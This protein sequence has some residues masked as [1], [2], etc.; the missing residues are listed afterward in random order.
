MGAPDLSSQGP[1][2]YLSEWADGQQTIRASSLTG[3]TSRGA[4]DAQGCVSLLQ[5][6][7]NIARED[8]L[9]A[10]GLSARP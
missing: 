2:I 9:P 10:A 7:Q 5:G 6:P 4:E 3:G 1:F 8:L